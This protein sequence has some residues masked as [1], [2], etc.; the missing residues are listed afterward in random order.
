MSEKIKPADSSQVDPTE[1]N[2]GIQVEMEHTDSK[3]KAKVIALQHLA[4]D[5]RY[6][7]KL[8]KAKL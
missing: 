1:L 7:T 3:A 8:A 5:P 2:K 6:Y 4:E